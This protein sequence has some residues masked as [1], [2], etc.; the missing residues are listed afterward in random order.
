MFSFFLPPQISILTL[1]L[2]YYLLSVFLIKTEIPLPKSSFELL[3]ILNFVS[4]AE[5]I[6]TIGTIHAS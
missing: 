5:Y 1:W 2:V 6:V 4:V 3:I